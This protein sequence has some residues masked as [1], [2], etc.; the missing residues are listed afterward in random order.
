MNSFLIK[1]KEKFLK[2]KHKEIFAIIILIFVLLLVYFADFGFAKTT[3]T[4]ASNES[5]YIDYCAKMTSDITE[6][7]NLM[8]GSD[9]CKVIIN[10]SDGGES[11]IAYITTSSGTNTT[12]TPQIITKN[13]VSSPIILKE[14]YP[15]ALS[16]AIVCPMNTN[17]ATKLNIKYMITTLLDM[18]FDNIA[19]YSC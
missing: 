19:I 6:A 13:G 16:V 18:D 7:V 3:K 12:K 11:V 2:T 8:T 17:T 10:W 14:E 4:S 9:S 1:I 5:D 15:K